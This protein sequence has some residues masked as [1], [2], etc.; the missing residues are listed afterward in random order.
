MVPIQLWCTTW[1]C[2]SSSRIGTSTEASCKVGGAVAGTDLNFSE[3]DIVPVRYD[4][5]D[6]SKIAV[7]VPAMEAVREAREDQ[8]DRQAID[9]AEARLAA[10]VRATPGAAGNTRDY[11]RAE[12]ERAR[13]FNSPIG[14]RVSQKLQEAWSA[15]RIQ[16]EGDDELAMRKAFDDLKADI[17]SQ[18]TEEL[19]RARRSD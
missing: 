11:V 14:V 4:P 16:T 17:R 1:S 7:D 6:R 15:G 5:A 18:T 9:R 10:E 3:G 2:G 19:S 13:R 8:R 12:L